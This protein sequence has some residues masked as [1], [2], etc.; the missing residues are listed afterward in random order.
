MNKV[1]LSLIVVAVLVVFASC[2]TKESGVRQVAQKYLDA[3]GAYDIP[4]ACNYCTQETADGLRMI[5]STLLRMVDSSYIAQN[6]P[7]KIK[8]T[9]IDIDSDTTAK[10]SYH[11][12][13]PLSEFDDTIEMRLRDGR[14]LAHKP[15][16]VPPMLQRQ[17]V[18]FNYDSVGP[19]E[20]KKVK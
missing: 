17:H 1:R 19:L 7:A 4:E 6:M 18:E 3:T 16:K 9:G 2:Q 5:D 13:T 15:V 8:I 11:K 14:W 20:E 12:K 10:V